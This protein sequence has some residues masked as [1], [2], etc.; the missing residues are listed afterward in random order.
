LAAIALFA[1]GDPRASTIGQAEVRDSAGV[2]WVVNHAPLSTDAAAWHVSAEPVLTIGAVE[3]EEPYLFTA[4]ADATR[5][6]DGRIV[7][8]EARSFELRAFSRSG[9]HAWTS[10]GRGEGPGEFR[11]YPRA[12]QRLHGDS[13]Q[14]EDGLNRVRFSPDGELVEHAMVDW[15]RVGRLGRFATECSLRLPHFLNDGLV[16]G[17]RNCT[18]D[19]RER[20]ERS[21]VHRLS[22]TLVRLPWSLDAADTIGTFL[23]RTF[24]VHSVGGMPASAPVPLGPRGLLA[25]GG[26]PSRLAYA[27]TESYQIDVYELSEP[28]HALRIER[29]GHRRPPTARELAEGWEEWDRV[30]ALR[31]LGVRFG[32]DASI[33]RALDQAKGAVPLPDSISVVEQLFVDDV[34]SIWVAHRIESNAGVRTWAV[35]RE[36]G[37]LLAEVDLPAD[38]QIHEIGQD[39]ILGVTTDEVGVPTVKLLQLERSRG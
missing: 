29:P 19:A 38:L 21:G 18:N 27:T 23:H 32:S 31:R 30:V 37:I 24:W 20:V 15:G 17:S 4:I 34:N 33:A 5:L 35:F 26:N 13:I 9:I 3:G 11:W 14:V 7:V 39:H 1:C 8:L 16:L 22:T 25:A 10:G 36:D 2:R 6:S 28:R 12:L